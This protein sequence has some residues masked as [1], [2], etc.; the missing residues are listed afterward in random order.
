MVSFIDPIQE[1][2]EAVKQRLASTY[3]KEKAKVDAHHVCKCFNK[4]K[5]DGI[6]PE[7][8]NIIQLKREAIKEEIWSLQSA[9]KGK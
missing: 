7:G 4:E 2:L 9:T 1:I 3:I 6:F 5:S 8:M